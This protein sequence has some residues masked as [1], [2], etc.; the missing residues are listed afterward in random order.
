G[1]PPSSGQYA[2]TGQSRAVAGDA[3]APRAAASS[4]QADDQVAAATSVKPLPTPPPT[5][6]PT[7][8]AAPVASTVATVESGPG[9]PL[10]LGALATGILAIIALLIAL[11][12]RHRL[13]RASTQ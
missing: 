5:P 7:A 10:G 2:S 1:Q 11:V 6:M 8:A 3:A 4:P 12:A 13:Q 9:A